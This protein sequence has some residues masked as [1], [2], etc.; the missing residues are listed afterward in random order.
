MGRSRASEAYRL[1]SARISGSPIPAVRIDVPV[2]RKL[3]PVQSRG[4]MGDL[5]RPGQTSGVVPHLAASAF[6]F[7]RG[8]SGWRCKVRFPA[9]GVGTKALDGSLFPACVR[10]GGEIAGGL[11]DA[12]PP[13]EKVWS[14]GS[15]HRRAVAQPG[16]ALRP[17]VHLYAEDDQRARLIRPASVPATVKSSWLRDGKLAWTRS[18]IWRSPAGRIRIASRYH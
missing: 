17:R 7:R 13:A 8:R 9:R 5:I 2:A 10:P 12:N 4:E 15:K 3:P 14:S 11:P 16:I 1:L 6:K 18:H